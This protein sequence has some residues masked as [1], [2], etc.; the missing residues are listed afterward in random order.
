MRTDDR[1]DFDDPEGGT[2]A[3]GLALLWILVLVVVAVCA[4]SLNLLTTIERAYR[5][6]VLR[7]RTAC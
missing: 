3:L 7:R 5:M 1:T 2:R 6:G 4:L